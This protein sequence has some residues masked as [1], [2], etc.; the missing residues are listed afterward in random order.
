M[1]HTE[2]LGPTITHIAREKAGILRQNGVLV[3]LPQHPEANQVIGEVATELEVT[4]INAAGYI[5]Y[6]SSESQ[7]ADSLRNRYSLEVL[8]EQIQV[9]SPLAGQHQQR[10]IALAI[11][12]AVALR[13]QYGYKI[14]AADIA[15]GIQQTEWPARLELL[16]AKR[17]P[18]PRPAILLDVAHNPAGAWTLRAAIRA[19]ES[20]RAPFSCKTLLFGCLADKPIAQLAQILFP[21]F[22]QIILTRPSS[23]R[24]ADPKELATFAATLGA[25][26]QVVDDPAAALEAAISITPPEGLLVTAGSVYLV[27]QLRPLLIR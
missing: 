13:N 14:S 25:Q 2:W 12:A 16:P 3:T 18:S 5:P 21:L 23:P 17:T 24:A 20:D 4:A 11:A 8:G 10:N 6:K 1:D 27:G 9:D 19:L 26:A 22:D 15:R 7:P